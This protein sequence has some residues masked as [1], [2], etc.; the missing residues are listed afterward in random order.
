MSERPMTSSPLETDD[1]LLLRS[2]S[3]DEDAFLTLYRSEERRVGK[4]C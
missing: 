2:Q 1:E 3:G 4:E